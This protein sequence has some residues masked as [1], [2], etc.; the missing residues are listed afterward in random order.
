MKIRGSDIVVKALED[1]RIPFT[2]G[3]P[4]THNIELYDSLSRSAHVRPILVT[5]EQSAGFMA[6]GVSQSSNT[7]GVVNVVPGAGLTHALSGIAE[8][9][10]DGVA[11]L[12][13]ACGVRNDTGKAFQLHDVD[14]LE[15][16]RPVT[17]AQFRVKHGSEIYAVIRHAC[18]IARS[19]PAGPVAV[20]IPA[21]HYVF[22]H[23]PNFDTNIDNIP[24]V[25]VP[26]LDDLD[27]VCTLLEKSRRP[28]LYLGLGAA[29][30]GKE[31]VALAERF[32]SPVATTIQGKGVFPETHPLWL[33]CGFGNMAPTFVR[34]VVKDCD[35]TL[36]IGCRFAEVGTGSYG[37]EPPGI[38]IHVDIDPCVFNQNYSAE[39]TI[40]ADAKA[41]VSALL[42]RLSLSRQVDEDLR[43][44]I[45]RGHAQVVTDWEA[46]AHDKLV[47]PFH[48]F[49]TLQKL[50]GSDSIYVTDS[51]NGS[52][53]AAECLRI[54]RP[55]SFLAPVDYSC[56]GY[57]IPSAIGAAFIC[58]N[59]PV[60]AFAGDGAFL[61]TGLELLTAAEHQ[62]PVIVFI[63][64]DKE[65]A[66]IAQFQQTALGQKTC[67]VLPDYDLSL[68]CRGMSVEHLLLNTN[69][70]IEPV[71]KRAN[72]VVKTGRPVVVEVAIDYSQKTYFT[73]GVVRTNFSRLPW[74][75]RLRF[76]TRVLKRK[77]LR[78]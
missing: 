1:E 66:Q 30:A 19:S 63:L 11:L 36:A 33:W 35:M 53:L 50:L 48:L 13:L 60:V 20:E 74:A 47:A 34:K 22:Y 16:V 52:F 65:L 9:Y 68:L 43:S 49:K 42:N 46:S 69:S 59:R 64:R 78:R 18:H 17:K 37:L 29:G 44:T 56:M 58:Q 7:L 77:G 8:A 39:L 3:I 76:I 21:N 32:G 5:D 62:L 40:T 57:A 4:G 2:F 54:E 67:S 23:E 75:D 10:M 71:L 25:S 73:R 51:G 26:N 27:R 70:D 12:V 61:M 45:L 41:F 14:Q 38:L 55:Y 28:L 6:I 15:I 72:S 31:L 24:S